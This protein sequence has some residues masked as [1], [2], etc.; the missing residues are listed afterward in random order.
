M[1]TDDT[2][3]RRDFKNDV[4][5]FGGFPGAKRAALISF[6]ETPAD[7][8]QEGGRLALNGVAIFITTHRRLYPLFQH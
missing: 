6:H 8:I 2:W 5:T 1:R 4:G 3:I 7:V